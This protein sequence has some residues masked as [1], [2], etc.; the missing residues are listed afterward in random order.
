[1]GQ[2]LSKHEEQRGPNGQGHRLASATTAAAAAAAGPTSFKLEERALQQARLAVQEEQRQLREEERQLEE[3]ENLELITRK[4]PVICTSNAV[5]W[6]SR[7]GSP[8]WRSSSLPL[9]DW[10][11]V[12][13]SSDSLSHCQGSTERRGGSCAAAQ[14]GLLPYEALDPAAQDLFCGGMRKSSGGR[15]CCQQRG[16]ERCS[17][18]PPAGLVAHPSFTVYGQPVLVPEWLLLLPLAGGDQHDFRLEEVGAGGMQTF[19]VASRSQTGSGACPCC[20]DLPGRLPKLLIPTEQCPKSWQP[21]CCCRSSAARSCTTS[22]HS[23]SAACS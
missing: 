16:L 8:A 7:G 12:H 13:D 18:G 5:P 3:A 6:G 11:S 15:C 21:S 1:M 9:A 23:C 2:G 17:C 4:L 22:W 14:G 19:D 20:G 10:G